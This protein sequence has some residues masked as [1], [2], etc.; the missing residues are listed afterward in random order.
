MYDRLISGPNMASLGDFI[1]MLW[2]LNV[3]L[4]VMV[5]NIKE[6]AKVYIKTKCNIKYDKGCY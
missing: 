5:T 4:V 6:A 2:E 1:R 3:P